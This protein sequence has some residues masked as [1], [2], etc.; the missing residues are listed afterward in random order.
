MPGARKVRLPQLVVKALESHQS[1]LAENLRRY[2]GVP[3][4][5][6]YAEQIKIHEEGLASLANAL[7]TGRLDALSKKAIGSA[8]SQIGD[9]VYLSELQLKRFRKMGMENAQRKYEAEWRGSARIKTFPEYVKGLR[10]GIRTGN[11]QISILKKHA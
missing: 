4:P 3:N 1:N 2:K 5:R 8:I 10:Q 11:R 7:K 9:D 6:K